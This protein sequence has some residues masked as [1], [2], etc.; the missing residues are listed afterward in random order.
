MCQG[1][2]ISTYVVCTQH[3]PPLATGRLLYR[4]YPWTCRAVSAAAVSAVSVSAV[5]VS[6]VSA[7]GGVGGVGGVWWPG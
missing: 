6:A 4:A 3:P 5:S 7:A 2:K 1:S